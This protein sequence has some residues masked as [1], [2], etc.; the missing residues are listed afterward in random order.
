MVPVG[1][2]GAAEDAFDP[3]FLGDVVAGS[4]FGVGV[5]AEYCNDGVFLVENDQS[6]MEVG[7]RDVVAL[8]GYGGWHAEA[9]DDLFDEIAIEVVMHEASLRLVIA[10]ANQEARRVVARVERHAVGRIEFFEAVSL[11]A[12]VRQVFSGLVVFENVVASIT[13]GQKDIA[14]RRDGDGCGVEIFDGEARFFGEGQLQ[15]DF[16]ALDFEFDSFGV[17]IACAVDVLDAVVLADLHVVN[18]GVVFS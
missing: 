11:G 13:V 15:H 7:D 12:E 1:A 14:V 3:I 16:S 6:A 10:V 8:D 18:A 5:V 2:V 17:G 9:G 4:F